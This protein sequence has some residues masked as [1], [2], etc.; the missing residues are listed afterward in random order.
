MTSK[1]CINEL[2]MRG[3]NDWIQAAEIAS[4]AIE[5][6]YASS[7]QEIQELSITIIEYVVQ[8]GL[9]EIGDLKKDG[10]LKWT[11]SNDKSIELV[12]RAWEA[13][14]RNPIL[15][16][17][18]WLQITHEGRRIGEGLFKRGLVGGKRRSWRQKE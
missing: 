15:G 4:I 1:E 11:C 7:I 18:C 10:F 8:N 17:I 5:V 13:L 12:K 2:L 9:M 14:N 16:E 3:C 6:G